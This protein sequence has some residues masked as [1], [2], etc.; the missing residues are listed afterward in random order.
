MRG[1]YP[2]VPSGND[3]NDWASSL[4]E[5][6][7]KFRTT[8]TVSSRRTTSRALDSVRR[9]SLPCTLMASAKLAKRASCLR[10]LSGKQPSLL[11]S[12]TVLPGSL[13]TTTG[14]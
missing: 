11:R 13:V 2:K 7:F 12:S 6:A 1:S 5:R 4:F 10:R 9:R 14:E 8:S 3:E